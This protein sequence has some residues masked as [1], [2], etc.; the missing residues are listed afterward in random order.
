MAVSTAFEALSTVVER[1]EKTDATV[2]EVTVC[3]QAIGAE[4]ELTAELTVGVPLFGAS[5]LRDDIAIEAENAD[6][7]DQQVSIDLTVTVPATDEHPDEAATE[8]LEQTPTGAE[9]ET[10]PAYK[11][12]DALAT[13]YAECST[14][15]EMVDALGVDVTSETVR[16]HA[17]EY[18]IHDPAESIPRAG[19]SG[20]PDVETS[21]DAGTNEPDGS[22]GP[23]ETERTRTNRPTDTANRTGT[24][25]S[26]D[27]DRT[28]PAAG[29]TVAEE[30]RPPGENDQ[31]GT[32][33]DS[34]GNDP[35]DA[36]GPSG[37]ERDTGDSADGDCDASPTVA[38]RSVAEL[39]SKTDGDGGG[40]GDENTVVA[41]GLGISSDLTV[42]N[43]AAAVNQS[44]TVHE[45]KQ[46]LG[47]S[48]DNARK[49]LRRL[50]LIHF[51]SH[52]LTGEQLELTPTEVVRRIDREREHA[53]E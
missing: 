45:A 19:Q 8:L 29:T 47:M 28:E 20:V 24:T 22:A 13:A 42:G 50:D 51:V 5:K 49:L 53:H 11:D 18:D 4:S 23:T 30:T 39:L 17:I 3:E 41:D 9:P 38:D 34:G 2:D 27:Q 31:H 25:D 37:S 14:F 52:P 26:T 21:P 16:R 15:P 32:S 36:T 1:L 40:G 7:R 12:P 33:A 46:H 10:T 43:F 48:Q 44:R 35:A 6:L